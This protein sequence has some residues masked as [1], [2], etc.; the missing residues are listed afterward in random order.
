MTLRDQIICI[1]FAS[2]SMVS[3][4][5][6]SLMPSADQPVLVVGNPFGHKMNTIEK[7]VQAEGLI[8][9]LTD[10]SFATVASSDNPNFISLLYEKGA[11]LVVSPKIFTGCFGISS[12]A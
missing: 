9:R 1:L 5:F 8:I 7:I 10:F 12:N 2:F 4:T 3:V 6:L 11:W